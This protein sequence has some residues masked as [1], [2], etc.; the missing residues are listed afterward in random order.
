MTGSILESN[1]AAGSRLELL[2]FNLGGRQ[3]FGINVFKVQEVIPYKTLTQLPGAHPLVNGVATLRGITMSVIDLSRAIGGPT[4]EKP[5]DGIIIITEYNRSVHGFLV[6]GVD[7]IVYTQWEDVQPPPAALGAHSFATAITTID[8]QLVEILDVEKV[9]DSIVHASTDISDSVSDKAHQNSHKVLIVDDSMVARKQ[10]VRALEQVNIECITATDGEDTIQLLD[11]LNAEGNEMRNYFCMIISDIEMPKMDGYM[12]TTELR[13]R[14][15]F[16]QTYIL[17]H[18][19]I[20]GE[21][22][23]EMV[24]KTGAN[25]FIQK[26]CPDELAEA[27]IAHLGSG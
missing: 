26:Y 14:P 15:D 4:M 24:K 3:L 20:S 5:K 18:S 25:Q 16:Q 27:V 8:N 1:R 19:S 7:R 17:L 12:L 21:F 10:I 11:K 9:L 22:N 2:L 13:K 23:H 6:Q